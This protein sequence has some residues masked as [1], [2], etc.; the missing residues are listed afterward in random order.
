MYIFIILVLEAAVSDRS[1]HITTFMETINF[2]CEATGYP[3]SALTIFWSTPVSNDRINITTMTSGNQTT[4][5][6]TVHFAQLSDAG[7]YICRISLGQL[8]Q[9]ILYN[10]NVGTYVII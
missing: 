8:M 3:S 5:V 1:V 6:L 10:L 9:N 4:S 7:I 2:T